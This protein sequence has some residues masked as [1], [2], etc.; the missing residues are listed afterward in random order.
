VKD[1]M[2]YV[3]LQK[4]GKAVVQPIAINEVA[5]FIKNQQ[6]IARQL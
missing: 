1:V 5:S 6:S 3:L 4:I 2:N